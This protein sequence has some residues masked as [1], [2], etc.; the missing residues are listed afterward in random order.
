MDKLYQQLKNF[1]KVK[2]K[3]PLSKHLTMKVGG[4]ARYF[5][6][7]DNTDK[8]VELLKYLQGEGVEY[9]LIGGGSNLIVGDEGFE[10]VVLK[11]GDRRLEIRDQY[12]IASSGCSMVDV[13]RKSIDAGLT[14][15]EWAIGIPGTIGGAV[16]GNAGA[17]GGEMKDNVENV[18][19]FRDGEVLEI[20][21]QECEFGYR[22]SIFKHNNDIVLRVWLKLEKGSEKNKMKQAL[23]YIK[24]RNES[25]PQGYASSGC[26]FKNFEIG[27]RRSEISN[28]EIPEEFIQKGIIPA[29]WLIEA[30]GMKGEKVGG[31]KVSEKHANFIVNTG[32]AT[33][34]DILTLIE[35]IKEKVYSK[36]GIELE[37]EI[38]II[39]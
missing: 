35:K 30:V 5:V 24:K 8:L 29:G 7:I 17:M 3:E 34:S 2:L 23:E 11:T 39:F 9:L 16:R 25:Q 12:A 38:K 36:F 31:A 20:T 6:I 13:A 15:F 33:A 21:N 18:E 19:V 1:G 10:G 28:L 4:P 37:E 22:D 32:D 14:G 27:D 26:I